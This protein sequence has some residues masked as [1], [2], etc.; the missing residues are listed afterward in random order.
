L[1]ID[2]PSVDMLLGPPG[3][4]EVIGQELDEG[5]GGSLV[6]RTTSASLSSGEISTEI[7][8]AY[9]L[10]MSPRAASSG[11]SCVS[12]DRYPR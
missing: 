5:D 1:L 2:P 6:A 8:L 12:V 11:V 4:P 9:S 10:G 3:A 7:A